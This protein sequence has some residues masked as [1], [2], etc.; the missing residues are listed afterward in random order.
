MLPF[1]FL[2]AAL[3][4]PS[5]AQA[6]PSALREA[7]E[8]TQVLFIGTSSH[9]GRGGDE[10]TLELLR[11]LSSDPRL[12]IIALERSHEFEPG[13]K[14]LSRVELNQSVFAQ[15]IGRAPGQVK[16][17]YCGLQKEWPWMDQQLFA[18]ARKSNSTRDA[19]HLV[20]V[21]PID[22]LSIDEVLRSQKHIR[23]EGSGI[24]VA[25]GNC[26]YIQFKT[27][28]FTDRSLDLLTTSNRELSTAR[29]FERSV[30][31]RLG[32]N[33]KA[34]VIYHFGHLL[35]DFESCQAGSTDGKN[36]VANWSKTSWLGEFAATHPE[37]RSKIRVV[38]L[39]EPLPAQNPDGLMMSSLTGKEASQNGRGLQLFTPSSFFVQSYLGGQHRAS[40]SESELFDRVVR[41][42]KPERPTAFPLPEQSFPALCR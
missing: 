10:L 5:P 19:S 34:I 35:R 30:R 3:F 4:L 11:D 1:C 18:W 23:D 36:W 17:A 22:G 7:Y 16:S 6:A 9:L 20:T 32:P 40:I 12:R 31:T 2:L 13:F 14:E 24:P 42:S 21:L 8:Q 15:R 37:A 28:K 41:L 27:P 25:T 39:D 33:D 29:N 38:L 26:S